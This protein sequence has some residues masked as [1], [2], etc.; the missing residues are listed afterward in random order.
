MVELGIDGW[1]FSG[2]F[3]LLVYLSGGEFVSVVGLVCGFVSVVDLASVGLFRL[4]VC[5]DGGGSVL[6]VVGLFH[7]WVQIGGWS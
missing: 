4:S 1:H 3:C 5:F 6:M 7:L 2:G